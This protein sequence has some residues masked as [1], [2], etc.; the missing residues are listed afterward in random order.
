MN[1]DVFVGDH[2]RLLETASLVVGGERHLAAAGVG[3]ERSVAL[4]GDLSE[5]MERIEGAD[6]PVVVLASGDP[7]FFG[8]VRLLSERLGPERLDVCPAP[9]SVALAFG[10]VGLS[11]EDAVVVSVHG[12]EGERVPRRAMNVCRAYPKVAVLTRPGFGPGEVASELR[13]IG[14]KF[15]VCERL[16]ADDERVFQGNAEDL[17]GEEWREPNVVLVLDEGRFGGGK[18]WVSGVGRRGGWGLSLDEFEY[19]SAMITRPETRSLV[20]AKLGPEA[21]EMIWDIGAGSGSIAVECARFGAAT[22]AV[23]RDPE[24][25][26]NIRSNAA[27]HGVFVDVVEGEAPG[28]IGDLPDPDAVFI[29]GS[30]GEFEEIV[31]VCAARAARS[32]VLTLITLERV[33][34]AM[35]LL[36]ESGY[37]VEAV[38]HQTSHVRPIAGMHRLVPDSQVFIV[39]GVR[40]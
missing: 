33:A 15:V 29:G 2:P 16:G 5:A 27:R 26:R 17:M 3:P 12:G 40:K 4:T 9:S 28:C 10:R 34:P 38:Q 20:L 7:G 24:S 36:E 8:I 25:C 23:E 31:R 21:G 1:G 32:V 37:E 35:R 39:S 14:R 22:I 18:S 11:W 30:G 6:G 19:R 13:K